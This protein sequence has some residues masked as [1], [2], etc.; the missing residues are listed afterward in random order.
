MQ[1][2]CSSA[3][4]KYLLFC[5][6]INFI[7]CCVACRGKQVYSFEFTVPVG[8]LERLRSISLVIYK[9]FFLIIIIIRNTVL[10][11]VFLQEPLNPT[12]LHWRC[13][14]ISQRFNRRSEM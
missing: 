10:L 4:I 8:A 3:T 9:H 7:S 6:L 12:H 2:H 11:T 13:L 5:V 1:L 14:S